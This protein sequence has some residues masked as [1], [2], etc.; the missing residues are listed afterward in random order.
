MIM[1][2]LRCPCGFVH[3]LDSQSDSA[4]LTLRDEDYEVMADEIVRVTMGHREGEVQFEFGRLYE[5]P[6]CGPLMWAKQ[7]AGQYSVFA[8]E[9]PAQQRRK[10]IS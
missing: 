7:D 3:D 2:S 6:E 9:P 4:W 10:S 8:P 1:A 5:R